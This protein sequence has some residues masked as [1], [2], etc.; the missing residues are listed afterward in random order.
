MRKIIDRNKNYISL[1]D[2]HSGFYMRSG[3]FRDGRETKEDPFMAGFPELLD[4]GIMGHCCHGLSGLCEKTG[5]ECYQDG[6]HMEQPNMKADDFRMIARQCEGRSYQ[7]ALGGRGDPDQH[8]DFELILKICREYHIVPNFTSSGL[9]FDTSIVQLCRDY[10]GAVAISWYNQP[11]TL[12]AIEMLVGAGVKTN[13]HFVLSKTSVKQAKDFL[14]SGIP[15]GVNA[16]IFLLHKPIGLGRK[17]NVL[18][19]DDT[20]LQD[21]YHF[22]NTGSFPHKVGFDSCSVPGLLHAMNHINFDALDTCEA[23]RWSAYV[24]PDLKLLPCSFDNQKEQWAVDLRQYTIAQAWNSP[25]FAH[26]RKSFLTSCP[27][28]SIQRQCM[29]GCPICKDI[30]LCKDR[31]LCK[32]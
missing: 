4:V 16:V 21:L 15:S 23:A 5:I 1:F 31:M 9:G 6:W 7:F 32:V 19:W 29:G 11:Y 3:V 25:K 28:C 30:V 17:E 27:D 22:I 10:C 12:R 26:F 8:E 2:E 18:L 13:I 20:D 24:T 14:R